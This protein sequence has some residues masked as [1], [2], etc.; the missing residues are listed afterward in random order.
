M[1]EIIA[2]TIGSI[3][4]LLGTYIPI[5]I[6]KGKMKRDLRGELA[7][8]V[9]IL[10]QTLKIQVEYYNTYSFHT[11]A[12]RIFKLNKSKQ[13]NFIYSDD[14]KLQKEKVEIFLDRA[15]VEL[16][17]TYRETAKLEAEI[18]KILFTIES[19]YNEE[20]FSSIKK[21]VIAILESSSKPSF[22]LVENFDVMTEETFLSIEEKLND[23][24]RKRKVELE[25]QSTEFRDL[26]FS[27]LK[28]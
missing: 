6:D 4:T 19:Y 14:I 5:W 25:A 24:I 3:I 23:K 2:F 16:A 9:H 15:S 26:L 1:N 18:I 8:T 20:K 28:V 17:T 10:Y 22:Y 13:P 11:A 27:I 12:I 7:A 21:L